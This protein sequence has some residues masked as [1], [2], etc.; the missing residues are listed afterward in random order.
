M[1]RAAAARRALDSSRSEPVASG[2][3]GMVS[4]NALRQRASTRRIERCSGG[5]GEASGCCR[6]R[7]DGHRRI[8]CGVR[9]RRRG[10]RVE[11][12]RR[13]QLGGCRRA[14]A[15]VPR[16]RAPPSR[17]PRARCPRP[18][19]PSTARCP[20]PRASPPRRPRTHRRGRPDTAAEATD[21]AAEAPSTASAPR[22][23]STSRRPRPG[24]GEGLKLG[25]IS[26]GDS[27]PFVKLV[28]DCD[29]ARGR[30]GRAPS[31]SSA[32]RR[33][34][35]QRRS[36]ARATSR[37]R[38]SHGV[39]ELPGR[40]GALRR[41]LRGR[42]G[43][44]GDRHRHRPGALPGRVHGRRQRV[45]RQHRRRGRSA[46]TPRTR[47][48]A[49]TTR[50]SRSSRPLRPTPTGCAWAARARASRQ[51]AASSRT[52]SVLDADRTDHGA[53]EVRRHADVAAR[54]AQDRRRRDQRR[55]PAR[56]AR[57]GQG[58]Q[59]REGD[60]YL[61]GQGADPTSHCEILNNP[62]WIADAALL[63]G[64]L[65]RDRGA[66]LIRAAKGETVPEDLL[67]PHV[68]HH[69]GQHRRV[70]SGARS[71]TAESLSPTW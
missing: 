39:P 15:G 11:R 17:R 22:A 55:R 27:V 50:T 38:T 68:A 31:S 52:R 14:V 23:S 1:M 54:Q 33:L 12:R 4:G 61:A 24:S 60:I 16:R 34:D 47:G 65:R 21:T 43:R 20:R 2:R 49:S 64:A 70:L 67:V 71:R 48:T 56:R 9:R 37:P 28:S 53:H 40:R 19:R 3:A 26:L 63:P 13:R 41:D 46:S 42:P 5:S 45:R 44:A 35:G 58:P 66:V 29:Q 36:T 25:Y 8:R 7:R 62:N 69:Q 30:G 57:R 32:T 10:H 59:G 51:S 6:A 18:P